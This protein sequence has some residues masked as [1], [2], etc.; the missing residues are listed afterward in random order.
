MV[1]RACRVRK[2]GQKAEA[3]EV[4]GTAA[5]DS[6]LVDT[7]ASIGIKAEASGATSAQVRL[8]VHCMHRQETQ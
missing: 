3:R 1:L 5:A 4:E 2:L 7:I 6:A 8:I